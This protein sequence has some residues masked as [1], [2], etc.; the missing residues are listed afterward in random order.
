MALNMKISTT[1][2]AS[3]AMGILSL[4]SAALAGI[5]DPFLVV[6]ASNASGSGSFIV[7][8]ADTTPSGG[9]RTYTLAMPIDI[10]SGPNVIATITQLNSTV[11]PGSGSVPNRISLAFTFFAGTSDTHFTVDSALFNI[12]PIMDEAGRATA[13]FTITDSDNDGV[14][15][16]GNGAGGNSF[17]A[18]YNGQAPGG[19]SFAELLLGASTGAGQSTTRN[20]S[21]PP[22]AGGFTPIGTDVTNMSDR[23]DFTLTSGDQVGVTSAFFIVPSPGALSLIGL[24]GLSLARRNRR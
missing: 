11:V 23:W 16:T 10:M 24:A 14:T 21:S 2:Y 18:R 15:L 20:A 19:T 1:V 22:G 12:A 17:S 7:P 6:N 8:L 9:G 4:S 5:S 13:G 3:A